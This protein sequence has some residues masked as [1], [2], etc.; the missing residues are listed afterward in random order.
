MPANH[1]FRG[2]WHVQELRSSQPCR[3]ALFSLQSF[4]WACETKDAQLFHYLAPVVSGN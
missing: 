1:S 2:W 3:G 4:Q